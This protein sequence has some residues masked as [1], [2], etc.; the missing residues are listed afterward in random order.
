LQRGER[1]Q[2]EIEFWVKPDPSL[3]LSNFTNGVLASMHA[4]PVS[5]HGRYAKQLKEIVWCTSIEDTE[6][7][8]L[9]GMREA[10]T[11]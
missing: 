2:V 4:Q 6:V 8:L 1:K 10:K 7:K 11:A 3:S 9:D 5:F